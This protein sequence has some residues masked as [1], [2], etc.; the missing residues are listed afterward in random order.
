MRLVRVDFLSVSLDLVECLFESGD[1]QWYLSEVILHRRSCICLLDSSFFSPE[2]S[3]SLR[4][5]Q[6]GIWYIVPER[7]R[8]MRIFY[9]LF[10]MAA[11]VILGPGISWSMGMGEHCQGDATDS[12]VSA[13]QD[14]CCCGGGVT[15]KT[16]A[17]PKEQIGSNCC[18]STDCSVVP[19]SSDIGSGIAVPA[20]NLPIYN[21]DHLYLLTSLRGIDCKVST[22]VSP[23]AP[24]FIAVYLQNCSF[25]I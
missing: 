11:F 21:S 13:Q 20:F 5:S 12:I 2:F 22:G 9:T 15:A 3:S 24:P 19:F 17:S 4:L 18:V 6:C 23:P 14:E 25:L 8:I 16:S 1:H 10:I 7:D